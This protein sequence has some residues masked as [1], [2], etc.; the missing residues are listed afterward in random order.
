MMHSSFPLIAM[1]SA[2]KKKPSL[3][4]KHVA[5]GPWILTLNSSVVNDPKQIELLLF[6]PYP[7]RR[8]RILEFYDKYDPI[9]G[10]RWY[11]LMERGIRTKEDAKEFQAI[12]DAAP[13]FLAPHVEL[14]H[15]ALEA[16]DRKEAFDIAMFAYMLALQR[17][18]DRNGDWPE[19]IQWA[20]FENR[21]LMR[22]LHHFAWMLWTYGQPD[23]AVMILRR[24]L[25]MNPGDNQGVRYE[26]LAI[27][28]GL[29]IET[30]DQPFFAKRGP[31]A[32]VA[33][34]AQKISDWFD[35]EAKKFPEEYDRMFAEWKKRE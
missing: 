13:E 6:P 21:P 30:W 19:T 23:L 33:W 8:K 31:M 18:A 26:I 17:I 32:G 15:A 9:I 1:S 5:G 28:L 16:G 29:P 27:R 7:H 11:E 2:H 4:K 25:R 14:S 24:I 34:D 10:D 20:W 35:R 12:R 3:K 22:A